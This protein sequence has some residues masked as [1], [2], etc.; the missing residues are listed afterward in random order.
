MMPVRE[1]PDVG[2]RILDTPSPL[3]TDQ[4]R[5]RPCTF[6]GNNSHSTWQNADNGD[7]IFICHTCFKEGPAKHKKPSRINLKRFSFPRLKPKAQRV[8]MDTAGVTLIAIAAGMVAL[9]L[10]LLVGGVAMF[11]LNWRYSE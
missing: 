10:G 8:M 3:Y 6:C 7:T 11:A 9:P 5:S 2:L 4:I 1:R